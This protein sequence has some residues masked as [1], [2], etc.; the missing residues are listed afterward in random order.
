MGLFITLAK[1]TAPMKK[2]AASAGTLDT[3]FG[4]FA[5]L[6]ILTMTHMPPR[7]ETPL[8]ESVTTAAGMTR[9]RAHAPDAPA[10]DA[11]PRG[12]DGSEEQGQAGRKNQAYP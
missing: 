10:L 7:A 9:L 4:N 11:P 1:P 12:N 3:V 8:S 2:G 6:Q 5:R